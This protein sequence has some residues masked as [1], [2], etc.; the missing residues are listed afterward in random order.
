MTTNGPFLVTSVRTGWHFVSSAS[1]TVVDAAL[2]F[3][4]THDARIKSEE[5]SSLIFTPF[6]SLRSP[7]AIAKDSVMVRIAPTA[8]QL[9]ELRPSDVAE[10]VFRPWDGNIITYNTTGGKKVNFKKYS[11]HFDSRCWET[12]EEKKVANA[13][14]TRSVATLRK[15]RLLSSSVFML[16]ALNRKY[17]FSARPVSSSSSSRLSSPS[18]KFTLFLSDAT[19]EFVLPMTGAHVRSGT[20]EELLGLVLYRAG[21]FK[22]SSLS[23]Q[24]WSDLIRVNM[25]RPT[26]LE[27][28]SLLENDTSLGS[29]LDD[30]GGAV[31]NLGRHQLMAIEDEHVPL[32]DGGLFDDDEVIA[33]R[34]HL[35]GDDDGAFTSESS[36]ASFSSSMGDTTVANSMRSSLRSSSSTV[37]AAPAA[38]EEMIEAQAELPSPESLFALFSALDASVDAPTQLAPSCIVLPVDLVGYGAFVK[39]PAFRLLENDRKVDDGDYTT[40]SLSFEWPVLNNVWKL[41]ESCY[42]VLYSTI[43]IRRVKSGSRQGVA[44]GQVEFQL[45][46]HV[47]NAPISRRGGPRNTSFSFDVKQ[48]SS[49]QNAFLSQQCHTLD[50]AALFRNFTSSLSEDR[51]M[52]TTMLVEVAFLVRRSIMVDEMT[53]RANHP[54]YAASCGSL[55]AYCEVPLEHIVNVAAVV[56]SFTTT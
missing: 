47:S 5:L 1:N 20:T 51:V 44:D 2:N 27:D 30:F 43:A 19:E 3:F 29:D 11:I 13:V 22:P 36:M 45:V 42:N 15:K 31:H 54:S 14:T 56:S 21:L 50:V 25:N 52:N 26:L 55:D 8:A 35:D 10:A 37:V 12:E 49:S 53:V 9:A 6:Q 48:V 38:I 33:P 41:T 4:K 23:Y 7:F 28:P 16:T 32:F 39:I 17:H 18:R 24:G 34:L 46:G 40:S